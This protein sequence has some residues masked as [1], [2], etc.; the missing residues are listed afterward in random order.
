[1]NKATR[2]GFSEVSSYYFHS[3]DLVLQLSHFTPLIQTNYASDAQAPTSLPGTIPDEKSVH[4]LVI[5]YEQHPPSGRH[6]KFHELQSLGS[7]TW[8]WLRTPTRPKRRLRVSGR[9][10]SSYRA[11]Y[12]RRRNRWERSLL[13]GQRRRWRQ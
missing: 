4:C 12:R 10:H 7:E 9:F 8:G 13:A 11:Q 3:K 1:M 2:T 6:S 5:P